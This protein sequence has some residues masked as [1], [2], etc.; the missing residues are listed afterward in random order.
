M[1]GPSI[2]AYLARD[3][4]VRAGSEH[5]VAAI[6]REYLAAVRA[7]IRE[8]H[9][10]EV[11]GLQLNATHSDL[12]DRLVRRM[13]SLAEE[14][15]LAENEERP[16]ELCLV[17]V[18]G[19]ARRE[20]SVHSDVDLLFLYRDKL[21]P[22]V[23]A[24][25][26]RVQ[27]W[28]W[29]AQ[30]TVGGATRTIAETVNLARQDMTVCTAVMAPRFLVG[31][32]VL[33]HQFNE[34]MREQLFSKP[35]PFIEA[36]IRAMH[37]RHMGHGDTLYLLQPNLKEGAGGLRDYHASYWAMQASGS[38]VRGV[39]DFLYLGLL[40]EDEAE[41]YFAA[42]DFLWRVRNEIHL[43]SG[44]KT[45]QLSFELQEQVARSFGYA[46][47][48]GEEELPVEL[49]MRDY[50]IHA[51]AILNYSSLVLEQCQ[52]RVRKAPR[53]RRVIQTEGDL[54]VV[55]GKL[56]IPHARQLRDR[57][58][59]LIEAFAVA[60]D[61]D[62]P[63]TRKARRTIR[64]NLQLIDDE[65]RASPEAV[66]AFFRVLGGER[67]VTSTLMAMNEVGLL[68]RFLP[69]WEQIVCRWQHIMYHTFTVDVH[70]V[71][72]V[73]Q[74]RRIRLG[75]YKQELP[76][77]SELV[78]GVDDLTAVYLGCLLHDV[79]KGLGGDH[80]EKGAQRARTC[81]ERMQLPSEFVDQ[82]VFLVR[83]HLL[84]FHLA[85]RRDLSDP[86]L[87]VEFARICG[88]RINLRNLYLLTVA[89]I[90]ASS[91]IA[92]TDWKGGLL[93]E[94]FERSAELL[95]TG[96][97]DPSVARELLDQRVETRRD[98]AREELV[99]QGLPIES[100]EAFFDMMPHRYLTAHGPRQIARHARVVLEL[101]PRERLSMSVREMR[102]DFS[103]LILCTQDVHGLFSKVAGLLTAHGVNI[104]GAHVYTA[105]SGLALEIYRL[106][107]PDGGP[108]ERALLWS[109][110]E[111]SLEGVLGGELDVA[112]L[113]ARR[114]RRV[115]ATGPPSL[116][117]EIVNVTNAESDF[118]TIVD[119]S[120][121]DRPGLLHDLTRVIAEH[122]YEIYIS[123]AGS[124]LDQVADTF[125]LKDADGNKL[126]DENAVE[127]LRRDLLEVARLPEA[128]GAG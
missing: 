11:S 114:G 106:A 63:L 46:D 45:D 62:V 18:G 30:V 37:E 90:R 75:E 51:R 116:K 108:E 93:R 49:F 9:A 89:D 1:K 113:L 67:R 92:W 91:S 78:R 29:D 42:L 13:F 122:G 68:A 107:T 118:Y 31:S 43:F 4:R 111:R 98:A 25:A 77:V 64:E 103:E 33:F 21:T 41:E 58:L 50:Y 126:R 38:S 40:T 7:Y 80:S 99:S 88:D 61:H 8:L 112:E 120:A 121:N 79:G 12:I 26:E 119:V 82:V 105:R 17:A 22:H 86:R 54:R 20:M 14:S 71:F 44:R 127:K 15:Y 28:L 84:M 109:D 56:E 23:A 117:P 69:E 66:A 65:F 55:D 104:L 110:F 97:D 16:S 52:Q 5:D 96:S 125:Y 124:V 39:D 47:D 95:E 128:A 57:P 19:Y 123:K 94:L 81:L 102:G 2:D 27:Y 48:I 115:G 32:G 3:L 87:I 85:Q 24:V 36:Q 100:V 74:L 59:L 101:E 72:L 35:E 73:E 70:S 34:M 6:V 53:R 60:Q 10:E 76:F 83:H